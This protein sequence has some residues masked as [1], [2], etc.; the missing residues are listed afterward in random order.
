[1]CDY[2]S[3]QLLSV[4]MALVVVIGLAGC[5]P[6]APSGPEAE[7]RANVTSGVAPLT[8]QFADLSV[9][10]A[11]PITAWSWLFGDG[12]SSTEQDPVH[13]Y[14]AAGK[15]NV[16]LAVTTANGED[17]E[18]KLSF[19]NVTSSG[20]GE[21]EGEGEYNPGDTQTVMLPDGV[22]LTM[23]W[24]PGGTFLMGRYSGEQDSNSD[25]DPQHSVTVLG[26][27][28][29]KYEVTQAQWRAITG[30]N[31]SYFTGD[32]RPVERVSWN[33]ITQTFLPA[34]NSATGMTFRLP[35][36]AQWE[37]AARAGTSTRFY[38][39][40]DP[41]YSQIGNYAWYSGNSG[42]ENVVGGKLPNAFGL[43]DMSGNVWEWCED[44]W[45]SNYSGAPADGSAWVHSPR[46][47][48]R[49]FRGGGWGN[50]LGYS[51]R[52]ACRLYNRPSGTFGG[53]VGF[54][55]SK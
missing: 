55:L 16:S 4:V 7:F 24:I 21:G 44:D 54:R 18:L 45:H 12:G 13:S 53:Y 3:K 1:M 15:Y 36:E 47:S 33:T 22:P 5:P 28:M 48:Y 46:G 49:V 6:P 27:W 52:S 42:S 32:N 19:V 14:M 51:C 40:D 29:G 26:F 43:Y 34:L 10:G 38:W 41:S 39:G 37:Y 9:P 17:T 25:E 11:S 23:V 35:S 8:V 30:G 20:E 50:L 2:N 31:P